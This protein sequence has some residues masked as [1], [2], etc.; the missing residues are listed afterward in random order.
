MVFPHCLLRAS[1]PAGVPFNLKTAVKG[2]FDAS[3]FTNALAQIKQF[4]PTHFTPTDNFNALNS[5]RVDQ[6]YPLN[7]DALEDAP[8]SNRFVDTTVTHSNH[9]TFIRLYPFL[10]TFSNAYP[11]SNGV[12]YMDNGQV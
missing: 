3:G 6:K 7:A 10:A 9:G 1:T 4:S 11:Y 2:L 8:H 5:G 12:A